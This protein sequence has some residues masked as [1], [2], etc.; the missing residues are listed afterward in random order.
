MFHSDR[1]GDKMSELLQN[2]EKIKDEIK[3]ILKDLQKGEN[4]EEAK[5]RLKQILSS[6]NPIMIPIVEQ[7]L[8]KEGVSP[9]E[10]VKMC[11]IHTELF[12]E[13]LQEN[14]EYD[15]PQGHPLTTFQMENEQISR[16]AEI[17][18]LYAK[19]MVSAEDI[20]VKKNILETIREMSKELRGVGYHYEREEMLLFPYIERRGITAVPTVLWTK[21]DEVRYKI[22]MF[23]NLVSG[24][25]EDNDWEEFSKKVNKS[26]VELGGALNDMV[27]RENN[28]LYPTVKILLS[29]GEWAAIKEQEKEYHYY[30]VKPKDE[31][32]PE[33]KPV[34]P[35][36]IDSAIDEESM[37]NMPEVIKPIMKGAQPDT[38]D[39][40]REGDVELDK[41]YMLPEEIK[42]IINTLPFDITFIDAEDRVRFFSHGKERIFPRS[43]SILGRP[44]QLCHPP[45]SVGIVN[46]ILREFK[47]GRRDMA[48]FWIQIMGK[49]IH[50][51]YFPVW[52]KDGKYLG[53][54]EVTQDA[55]HVRS[56]EGQKRLLDWS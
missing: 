40:I 39:L 16:D 36:E 32:K 43:P 26:A 11:D 34:H 29:E 44:V 45:K 6:L 37:V 53:T 14:K 42:Y 17:L 7:E 30:K 51:Q 23:L 10:I 24:N 19:S 47:A 50:I 3:E 46:K 27:Y 28:I 15:F 54:L 5:E 31:W 55:T 41:G 4:I 56:L 49:F 22:K 12:R 48:E 20:K 21:H 2:T 13:L 9:K 52:S 35:Y 25:P 33:E 8:V 1:V 18:Q 38:H